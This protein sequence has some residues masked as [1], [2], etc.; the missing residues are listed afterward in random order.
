MPTEAEGLAVQNNQLPHAL[1]R[2][3][4]E[5]SRAERDGWEPVLPAWPEVSTK[6]RHGVGLNDLLGGQDAG[7]SKALT[8]LP[9]TEAGMPERACRTFSRPSPKRPHLE[10]KTDRKPTIVTE[11]GKRAACNV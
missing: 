9:K 7:E 6:L 8:S 2:L 4:P 5:L 1:C 3:T 11:A 10:R